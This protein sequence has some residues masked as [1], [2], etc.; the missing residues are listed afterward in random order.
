MVSQSVPE[1]K[2]LIVGA[3]PAGAFLAQI[4]RGKGIAFEIFDREA[5]LHER[6]GGGFALDRYVSPISFVAVGT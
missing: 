4:L 2:V 6:K 5:D 3:G 1:P